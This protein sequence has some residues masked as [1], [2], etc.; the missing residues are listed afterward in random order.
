M[1]TLKTL[2]KILAV[3]L[4]IFALWNGYVF[5][6][7]NH[8]TELAMSGVIENSVGTDG[9]IIKN[10]TLIK[11]DVS[12]MV[13]AYFNEG[14]KVSKGRRVVSVV[15]GELSEQAQ[16]ELASVNKRIAQIKANSAF[17]DDLLSV[18]GQIDSVIKQMV[19]LTTEG[20]MNKISTL[21]E[22]LLGLI[23]KKASVKGENSDK[24]LKTL[25]D[26]KK[27]LESLLGNEGHDIYS[28][29]SGLY[30]AQIDKLEEKF[31]PA[32]IKNL[33]VSDFTFASEEIAP[34]ETA[35]AGEA[36]CKIIDNFNW[37]IATVLDEK[38]VSD[39]KTGS[40][41][42]IVISEAPSTDVTAFVEHISSPEKGKCVLVL[43]PAREIEGIVG[44]RQ[45]SLKIVKSRYK[46][47]KLPISALS[48]ENGE[49]GVYID[50]LGEKVFRRAEVVY[51][52]D[53]YVIF[54]ENNTGEKALLLYDNVILKGN[55][56]L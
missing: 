11:S 43:K 38:D 36:V 16:S 13:K 15:S 56:G 12:G 19:Q 23:D 17:D 31:S 48:V 44:K 46:G 51:K 20:K 5:L 52:N 21:K 34:E 32:N 6:F 53:E 2:Y 47:L 54:K 40:Y 33:K 49:T 10:E 7:R 35:K 1:L 50:L 42:T 30:S 18:D 45:V 37:Y 14:E 24:L 25:T 28:P 29:C 22:K 27:E 8:E 41:L 55:G 39:I 9:Y 26:R 4:I 3:L